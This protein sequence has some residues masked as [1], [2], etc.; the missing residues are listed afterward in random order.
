M[1]NAE[2]KLTAVIGSPVKH[3]LSPLL[4][5]TIY[6]R[7]KIDAIMMAFENDSIETLVNVMR[8][9]P[10]HLT[11]VTIP[12]KQSVI[13]LLDEIDMVA[14]KIGAVNTVINKNGILHGHNTDFVGIAKSLEK[15]KLRGKKV[16]V[17]GAG[18]AARPAAFHLS[19]VGAEMYCYNRSREN[20]E[21]LCADF[22][23]TVIED[24][25]TIPFDVIINTT[26]I[27]MSPDTRV[28]PISASIIRPGSTVFDIVYN[29]LETQ[30][31]K[32]AKKR[33][34]KTISGLTMFV[35]QALEQ[36]R[37]WLGKS[38]KDSGYERLLKMHLTKK[39]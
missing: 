26:P 24:L 25:T 37:L 12:F 29:P 10:I 6:A 39:K 17:M 30:L 23:G 7:Q 5:N 18:G 20:A 9:L 21:T 11:A 16:L 3:S 13:P 33:R 8:S 27:G 34:A 31:L 32:D 35:A 38:I 15:V 4:H 22:G 1:T 2:T 28:S 19:K 14:K 36:E